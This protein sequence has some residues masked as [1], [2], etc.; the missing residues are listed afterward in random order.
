MLL[1][2]PQLLSKD[3]AAAIGNRLEG[4]DWIDGRITAGHLSE[5]V[6]KNAQMPETH[7]LAVELGDAILGALDVNPQFMSAA[8]PL[9]VVPPLFNRY[10][11]GESYGNHVD[12]GIRP[13]AGT[14]HRVRSDLSATVFLCEPD[15]Y[16]GGELVIEDSYGAHSVK[17]P[18]GDMILYPSSSIHRV[19]P[20]TRGRRMASFFWIQSMIRDDGARSILFELDNALQHLG[21]AVPGDPSI[22]P[23]T[24]IYHNLLRRWAD[25]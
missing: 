23:L 14:R 17:L 9:K 5:K 8:L 7:P 13:V 1:H 24:N 15:E 16:D 18:A 2:I 21:G 4:A 25:T 22:L 19:Q 3:Q 11:P 6:K 20:V 12:G 10:G